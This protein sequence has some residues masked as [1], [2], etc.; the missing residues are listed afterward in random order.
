MATHQIS[1]LGPSTIPAAG[2]NVYPTPFDTLATNDVWKHMVWAFKDTST[3]DILYGSFLVPQNYVGSPVIIPVWSTSATS[4]NAIWDFD[5]RTVGGDDTTSLDQSGVEEALT[6][7]DAAP[8]AAWRRMAPTGM[9]A[10]ANFAAGETA[11]YLIARDGA[12]SD[13]IAATLAL[14][15]LL[16]QYSDS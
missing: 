12:S 1:I 3:R 16:F 11:T 13:T 14:F 4:G 7:T 6:V 15:D 5:Y 10:S 9:S 2:G 8:G